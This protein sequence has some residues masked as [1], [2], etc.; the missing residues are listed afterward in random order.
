M[1]ELAQRFAAGSAPDPP[2]DGFLRGEFLALDARPPLDGLAARVGALWMP[3]LGK[4]FDAAG[5]TGVNH[6]R[7]AGEHRWFPFRTRVARALQ[8]DYDLAANPRPFRA[9]LD[10][11]VEVAPGEYLGR[12]LLRTRSGTRLVGWFG[13]RR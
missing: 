1:E 8:L 13:L 12:A 4:S 3:W 7:V 9:V 6:W 10:E 5:G 11:V 2:L